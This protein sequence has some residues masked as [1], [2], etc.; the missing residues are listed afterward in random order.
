M[1]TCPSYYCGSEWE[2]FG[3]AE[4]CDA[5]HNGGADLMV[6]FRCGIT[7]ADFTEDADP[8]TIDAVKLMALVDADDAQ[9]IS[10]LQVSLDAPSAITQDIFSPCEPDRTVNYDHTMNIIDRNVSE[11]RRA[12]WNSVSSTSGFVNGGALIHECGDERWTYIDT[13]IVITVGRILPPKGAD[14]QR[15]ENSATWR[16]KNIPKI[17]EGNQ[18]TVADITA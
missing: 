1:A 8:E 6:L 11:P 14:V 5:I 13:N 16:N 3:G 4:A 2:T 7:A 17:F 12:A 9:I 15:F 10:G 18:P